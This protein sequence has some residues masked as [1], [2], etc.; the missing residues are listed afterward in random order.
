MDKQ[1]DDLSNF[2][3]ITAGY[4]RDPDDRKAALALGTMLAMLRASPKDELGRFSNLLYL[5]GRIAQRSELAHALF[6]PIVAAYDGPH[7]ELARVVIAAR[8]TGKFPDAAAIPIEHPMHL[9]LQWAEFFATGNTAVIARLASVLDRPDRVRA[10]LSRWTL[11]A[12]RARELREAGIDVDL[13]A[14]TIVTEGD[15]DVLAFAIAE[16]RIPIFRILEL[17]EEELMAVALKGAVIWALRLNA[18][19][20]PLVASVWPGEPAPADS[21]PYTL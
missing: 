3:A 13:D 7:V 16:K 17:S 4:Y 12:A 6:L 9:D 20:H 8:T 5:F 21:P 18:L 2:R 19:H 10:Y 1:A 11:S 15:L 14:R